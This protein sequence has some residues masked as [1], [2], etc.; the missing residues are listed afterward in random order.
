MEKKTLPLLDE[1]ATAIATDLAGLEQGF[2][3][4]AQRT[5]QLKKMDARL[6]LWH[7]DCMRLLEKV[8]GGR[9]SFAD[10]SQQ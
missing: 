1:Q 2:L 9:V 8:S 10:G 4:P 7:E 6:K 3:N 5:E